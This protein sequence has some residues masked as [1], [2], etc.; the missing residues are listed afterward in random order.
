MSMYRL[1]RPYVQN[2][3]NAHVSN[4]ADASETIEVVIVRQTLLELRS[5]VPLIASSCRIYNTYSHV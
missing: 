2:L 3:L 1:A 5:L 4:S